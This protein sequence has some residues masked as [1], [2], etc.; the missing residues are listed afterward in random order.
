MQNTS[1]RSLKALALE[2]LHKLDDAAVEKTLREIIDKGNKHDWHLIRTILKEIA[3]PSLESFSG[4]LLQSAA[5]NGN[6]HVEVYARWLIYQQ[7]FDAEAKCGLVREMFASANRQLRKLGIYLVHRDG[8]LE[9]VD[10]S[11]LEPSLRKLFRFR[12]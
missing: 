1:P 2:S 8:L 12:C 4:K 10:M 9:D 3:E 11:L 5:T 6:P 7:A